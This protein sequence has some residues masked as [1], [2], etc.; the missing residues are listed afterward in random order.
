MATL[1][2][3][4]RTE[5]EPELNLLLPKSALEQ[6]L[7]KSLFQNLD[8]YF[9]PKKQPPLVLTSKPVPVRDIWGFY[10]YKKNGALAST[11]VH[12]MVVGA[13]IG[14]TLL[15]RRVVQEMQ[16]PH[17]TVTL[18]APEDIPPMAPSKTVSG[19]GGGGGDRDK[20][21]APK[22]KLPKF[23]MEQI[24]PPAV[25]VR[26]DHPKLTAEPTVVVPPQVRLA[27]N[28]NMPNF[29]DPMSHLPSGPPSNGIGSGGGI[30][31]GSGGGV[32]VGEGPGVGAGRGGGTGGGV[33]HVGGGVSAPRPVFTPDP[34]YSEEARKAKY[35]GTC[36]LWLIVGPDGK[37]R[38][39][40]VSRTLGLGLDEKAIEAVKQWKFEPAMKDGKPV[41]VQINV[42]VS[43]RL[44]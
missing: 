19:G 6:P 22:G 5:P 18:V 12:V 31:S 26:N 2:T 33:F 21:Q 25:V 30:G 10:D 40:K 41:A 44:Y 43:F 13:I 38:D 9:F 1:E 15:G 35:Q 3:A 23:A 20:F 42:E 37:P 27:M 29:G 28:N 14:L 8:D 4:P 17:E 16:K 11:V 36:V 34:E 7:W 24:T 39:I 32:G